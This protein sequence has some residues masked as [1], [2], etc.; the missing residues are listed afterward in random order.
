MTI[1]MSVLNLTF[2]NTFAFTFMDSLIP[3]I[4]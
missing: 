1:I 2:L 3:I 4:E